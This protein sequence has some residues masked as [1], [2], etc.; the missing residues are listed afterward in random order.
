MTSEQPHLPSE[1]LQLPA[2]CDDELEEILDQ[3]AAVAS[4][5]LPGRDPGREGLLVVSTPDRRVSFNV[6]PLTWIRG[7][8]T[9]YGVDLHD[10][11]GRFVV[12]LG[13]S[14]CTEA[15]YIAPEDL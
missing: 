14:D 6:T 3:I 15:F 10:R 4:R 2:N 11:A 5:L 13:A 9:G 1:S 12:L 7:F 8:L